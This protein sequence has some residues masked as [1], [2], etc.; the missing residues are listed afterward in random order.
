MTYKPTAEQISEQIGKPCRYGWHECQNCQQ[1]FEGIIIYANE[2]EFSPKMCAPCYD[3]MER[4]GRVC[5]TCQG[6]TY[7]AFAPNLASWRRVKICPYC[8]PKMGNKELTELYASQRDFV[9]RQHCPRAYQE[10]DIERYPMDVRE[11]IA[12]AMAHDFHAKEK[13]GLFLYG[14]IGTGKTR[15]AWQVMK[16]WIMQGHTYIA[17]TGIALSNKISELSGSDA[18]GL[19]EYKELLGQAKLLF[20][21]DFG[22]GIVSERILQELHEVMDIR[23]GQKMPLLITSNYTKDDL[24]DMAARKGLDEV[25]IEG[26]FRRIKGPCQDVDFGLS[27][28]RKQEP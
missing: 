22:K 23:L 21:D 10:F 6:L 1:I 5:P 19:R 8:K 17:T 2:K 24:V 12:V 7:E 13:N 9:F 26:L 4:S 3:A 14:D 25:T 28:F 16:Q 18:T 20:I 15:T 11:K 27:R